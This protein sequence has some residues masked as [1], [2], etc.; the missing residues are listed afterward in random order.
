MFSTEAPGSHRERK[1]IRM[2]N[3]ISLIYLR[4]L[5]DFLLNKSLK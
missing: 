3:Y 2:I 1:T 4:P 5:C